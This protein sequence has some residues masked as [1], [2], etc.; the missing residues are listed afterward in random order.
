MNTLVCRMCLF[1][2]FRWLFFNKDDT[3]LL[4]PQFPHSLDPVFDVTLSDPDLSRHPLL[5][6]TTPRECVIEAG[7][8]KPSARREIRCRV[9]TLNSYMYRVRTCKVYMS[10]NSL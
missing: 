9:E 6:L 2:V 4:Y 1:F 7:K 8:F 10:R 5:S 3:A